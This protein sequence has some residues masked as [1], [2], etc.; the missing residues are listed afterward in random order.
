MSGAKFPKR[1]YRPYGVIRH[2]LIGATEAEQA[3][4]SK[5]RCSR[6]P[7]ELVLVSCNLGQC[8]SLCSRQSMEAIGI[9]LDLSEI[10]I[11]RRAQALRAESL[12]AILRNSGLQGN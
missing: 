2:S 3:P 10:Q 12:Q 11:A 8:T 5:L 9:P 4:R 1:H 7:E 6:L